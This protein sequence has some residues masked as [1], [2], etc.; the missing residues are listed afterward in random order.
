V[1]RID[2]FAIDYLGCQDTRL[3][4]EIGRLALIAAVRRARQPG[5]KFDQII[6]LEHPTQG[7]NKSSMVELL[8]GTENFSDQTILGLSAREQQEILG[9]VWGHEIAEL[10]NLNKAGVEEVKAFA[11]RKCD[12]ARPAYGRVRSD[13]PRRCVLF[14]TTNSDRYLRDDTGNRRFWPLRVGHIDL[15]AI[16]RDRDQLWGE[17]ATVEA[18][19]ASIQLDSSLWEA[20]AHEQEK[21]REIDPW[22]DLLR[23]A[24]PEAVAD[25]EERA[26]TGYMLATILGL[27]AERQ[28]PA[29]AR[30]LA[31]AARKAGWEQPQGGKIYLPATTRCITLGKSEAV[32]AREA[33]GWRRTISARVERIPQVQGE[34]LS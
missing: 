9:G 28:T 26:S 10:S 2:R 15:A 20:A 13:K 6:V 24:T 3:N 22:E 14:A 16:K 34:L 5:C 30:R 7:T 12:R 4:R 27:P 1:P 19:G 32:P 8:F 31:A 25:G 23:D 33:R 17:A 21:R 18:Q 29:N 11:S